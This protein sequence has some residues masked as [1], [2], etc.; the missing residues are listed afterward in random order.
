[1][2]AVNHPNIIQMKNILQ[3]FYKSKDPN[4]RYIFIFME[5]ADTDLYER[6]GSGVYNED[7]AKNYSAQNARFRLSIQRNTISKEL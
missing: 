7:K 6:Q 2:H 3:F 4:P 5:K 1:M